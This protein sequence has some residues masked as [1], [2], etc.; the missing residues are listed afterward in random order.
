MLQLLAK[1]KT[2]AV[3]LIAGAFLIGGMVRWM[4]G[5]IDAVELGAF[6]GSVSAVATVL[7]GLLS[8]DGNLKKKSDE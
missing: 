8:K 7:I 5:Q 4:L 6:S 3:A 1:H 2:T